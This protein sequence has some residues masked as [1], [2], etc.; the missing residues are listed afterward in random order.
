MQAP[1][2]A[3]W[4]NDAWI[5][6]ALQW[7][8]SVHWLAILH[9]LLS[10]PR[11]GRFWNAASGSIKDVQEVGAEIWY[12]NQ[13]LVPCADSEDCPGQAEPETV[14]ITCWETPGDENNEAC[15]EMSSSCPTP[16]IKIENGILYYWFCCQW[17][18]IGFV[19]S[20]AP[21]GGALDEGAWIPPEGPAP[22]P[23]FDC[24]ACAKAT[25]V[26]NFVAQVANSIWDAKS[27][28]LAMLQ[29]QAEIG[30]NLNDVWTLSAIGKA[31][32][33]VALSGGWTGSP[34]GYN[35]YD[36]W[37]QQDIKYRIANIFD[38]DC[39]G[40]P[41]DDTFER[42]KW[43]YIDEMILDL[44]RRFFWS[45]VL[46]AIGRG[47][48][49]DVSIA[50]ATQTGTDCSAPTPTLPLFQGHGEAAE[51][52]YVFDLRNALPAYA[53]LGAGSHHQIG[54]GVWADLGPTSNNNLP[55]V[56]LHLDQIDNGSVLTNCALIYVTRG[57]EDYNN[58]S[59]CKWKAEDTEHIGV[60]DME[61]L[62]GTTPAAAG[63]W[64]LAKVVSDPLGAAED[65]FDVGVSVYHAGAQ[66]DDLIENS[67]VIVAI[68]A[69]GTGP[70]PLSTPPA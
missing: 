6:Y 28:P 5:C 63:E 57:D 65:V 27:D 61:A 12:R 48:L 52:R 20:L 55:Q 10:N 40:I 60:A 22:D 67:V 2:P 36:V 35:L 4:T 46:N 26:V 47:L 56:K 68:L 31:L 21:S 23:P 45:H 50:G 8:D 64:T 15:D 14:Y 58:G 49:S 42:V 29:I 11:Q 59:G 34:T 7:P 69:A 18:Q 66:L 3:D 16:P 39:A 25:A 1:I 70:G 19:G 32:E 43:A 30:A 41:D 38:D 13:P 33:F 24:T 53:E 51:W 44:P 17:T 54:Q 62:T 37:E 9:G